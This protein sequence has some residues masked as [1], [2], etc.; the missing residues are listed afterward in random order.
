MGNM[1]LAGNKIGIKPQ[2]A[3]GISLP[4]QSKQLTRNVVFNPFTSSA[5]ITVYTD[6]EDAWGFGF[7]MHPTN[8]L[9]K[10]IFQ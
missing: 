10:L 3:A 6:I 9:G 4:Q 2:F 8:L 5:G 1:R 7:G